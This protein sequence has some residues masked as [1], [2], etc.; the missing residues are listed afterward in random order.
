MI[1]PFVRPRFRRTSRPGSAVL[2]RQ[3]RPNSRFLIARKNDLNDFSA[4]HSG[5]RFPLCGG[6]RERRR[7]GTEQLPEQKEHTAGFRQAR[8]RCSRRLELRSACTLR[9][10]N[11]RSSRI[12]ADAECNSRKT[13]GMKLVD[14]KH[15]RRGVRA[16]R[17]SVMWYPIACH[18]IA[19]SRIAQN[20]IDQDSIA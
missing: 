14:I 18:S 19:R 2:Y 3:F 13:V 12:P 16:E 7:P 6:K 11:P 1:P 8:C 9:Q 5:A 4:G 20:P 10:M 15:I 17:N